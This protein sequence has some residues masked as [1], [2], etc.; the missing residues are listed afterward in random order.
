MGCDQEIVVPVN[1]SIQRFYRCYVHV[2]EGAAEEEVKETVCKKI[3]EEGEAFL[4]P[5]PDLE[6]EEGDIGAMEI[7][8]D[9][10]WSE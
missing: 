6:I 10:T 1:V 3:L 8:W 4:V 2:Q 7:D 5:D 9:A